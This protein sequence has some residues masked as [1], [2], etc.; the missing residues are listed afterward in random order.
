MNAAEETEAHTYIGLK[1]RGEQ[2]FTAANAHFEWV[3]QHGESAVFEYTLARAM[4]VRR[5]MAELK[6]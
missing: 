3:S 1:L 4:N 5:S 2:K 6:L